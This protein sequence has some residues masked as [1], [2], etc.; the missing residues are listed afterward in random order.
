MIKKLVVNALALNPIVTLGNNLYRHKV[1]IFMLHRMASNKLGVEGHSASLLRFSLEFL[2][3]HKF[4]IVSIDEV[5]YAVEREKPLPSKSVAFTLDDGYFDQVESATDIFAE[6]DCPATFYVSTGFVQGDL[7]FWADKVQFIVENCNVRQFKQLFVLFPN[8][9]LHSTSRDMVASIII[10]RF[11]SCAIEKINRIISATA[12]QIGLEIPQVA[13]EKYRPTSW[14]DLRNIEKRGMMVG[15]HS[16]SHPILSREDDETSK[17]EIERSTI[18][19]NNE[20][21]NPSK[22]FCYPVGRTHDFSQREID[23]AMNLG[24]VGG[25]TSVPGAMDIRAKE[26]LFSIPRFSYPNTK[27]DFIQY[28]TWIESFKTQLRMLNY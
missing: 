25:I 6:F 2:R 8:L 27:E 9:A 4:N 13:P 23:Y 12:I 15:A 11:K 1:P 16:Y 19:V 5:A 20:L 21:Q 7:W 18:D 17:N 22:V 3:K 14:H 26:C 24:Y 28:A 10:K